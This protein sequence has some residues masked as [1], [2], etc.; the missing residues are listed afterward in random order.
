MNYRYT[1]TSIL[2]QGAIVLLFLILAAMSSDWMLRGLSILVAAVLF[3]DLIHC[4]SAEFSLDDTGLLEKSRFKSK[5]RM[6]WDTL[7]IVSKTHVNRRWIML[8]A[9]GKS[10]YMI[11]PYIENYENLSR[12]IIMYLKDHRIKGVY[13]HEDLLKRLRLN[14]KLNSDG[15]IKF[16]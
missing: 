13:V 6:H 14:I 11:K 7:E 10:Y 12:D 5:Y 16:D 15:L 8:R 4:Y 2:L 1:R 9:T 3:K